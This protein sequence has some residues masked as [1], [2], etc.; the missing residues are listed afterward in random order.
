ME[1]MG[2]HVETSRVPVS[3]V[4]LRSHLSGAGLSA[5]VRPD[6]WLQL[7]RD[8]PCPLPGA[9]AQTSASITGEEAP[10][11]FPSV[12]CWQWVFGP[13]LGLSPSFLSQ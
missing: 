6:D 11:G 8:L 13:Q 12:S 4:A 9:E 1:G 10:E 5:L 2:L 7:P 3:P